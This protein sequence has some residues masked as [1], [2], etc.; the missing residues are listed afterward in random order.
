MQ[1]RVLALVLVV[2]QC[3]ACSSSRGSA[4]RATDLAPVAFVPEKSLVVRGSSTGEPVTFSPGRHVIPPI[5]ADGQQG[6]IVIDGQS[7]IVLDLSGVDLRGTPFGTDLDENAGFGI[8]LKNCR[9]VTIRG[10]KLGGYKVCIAAFDSERIV[11]EDLDFDGWYGQRLRSTALAEDPADWLWPHRNDEREWTTNYGAAI[12]LENCRDTTIRRSR[13]RHG[14]NG[15]LLTRCE[16]TRVYDCDFSFLSGWGLA[17]Y[18]TNDSLV[19]R[20]RFDHCVR[21]YSHGVYWRG[22]DSAGILMFERCSRNVFAENS[23]SHG[24]DG[25]FLFAGRDSVEGLAEARG[26]KDVGGS[27]ANVWWRN[28]FSYAVANAIEATFSS[29]NWAIENRLDGSHQHGVWGGYSRRMVVL[30]NSIRDTRGGAVSIEHGQE[31]AIVG[32]AIEGNDI[33]VELWWDEDPALVGGP[34][35]KRHDTSSR[36]H[37][38]IQNRF[39]DNAQDVVLN[40]TTGVAFDR[41]EVGPGSRSLDV[42]RSRVEIVSPAKP[43]EVAAFFLAQGELPS[44]V[45]QDSTVRALGDAEPEWL[46]RARAWTPPELPGESRPKVSDRG[47]R[48]GLDTIV[49]G[50]WGPWDFESGEPRPVPRIPG[51]IL[52]SVKWDAA[53]FRWEPAREGQPG[54]GQDPRE[55]VVRWL[56]LGET[57]TTRRAVGTW[58]NPWAGDEDVRREIGSAHFGLVARAKFRVTEAGPHRL[59]V[60]SDDGVRVRIDEK[61]VLENWTWHAPTRDEATVDLTVGEHM[62]QLEYFQIDGSAALS[63][64]LV[65]P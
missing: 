52:A 43:I 64:E 49:M 9:D 30:D 35:G 46:A 65:G 57:A 54:S 61:V 13:G 21:G 55:D 63:I 27:D 42:E 31:C 32:N 18:R 50:E 4:R 56:A 40:R 62:I 58:V 19:A 47:G 1:P 59:S 33:G 60:V 3:V 51:G 39:A 48:A 26:E 14:Q 12:A 7:D 24:G 10:G 34:F 23:A 25:V 5:G 8:V 53:W 38:V 2:A 16:G 28:D 22:Q 15:I 36:D 44:G 37:L 6:V 29:D 17:L 20:N 45:V 11:L 41:N